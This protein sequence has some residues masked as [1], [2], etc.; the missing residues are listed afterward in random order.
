LLEELFEVEYAVSQAKEGEAYCRDRIEKLLQ[1]QHPNVDASRDDSIPNP[2]VT[3]VE[4]EKENVNTPSPFVGDED[5]GAPSCSGEINEA[6][7][8]GNNNLVMEY[9]LP[10]EELFDKLAGKEKV[11][12]LVDLLTRWVE[13]R[14]M[15][16]DEDVYHDELQEIYS[17]IPKAHGDDKIDRTGFIALYRGIEDLFE[18]CATD[19]VLQPAGEAKQTGVDNEVQQQDSKEI[20][21]GS[22]TSNERDSS[23]QNAAIIP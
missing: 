22:I 12:S 16:D 1:Q 19:D 11:I 10:P 15:L 9:D 17:R 6:D 13:L 14:E 7:D 3:E 5:K 2:S 20:S 8:S 21:I 18:D 23:M 4:E